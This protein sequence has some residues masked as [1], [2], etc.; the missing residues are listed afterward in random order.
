MVSITFHKKYLLYKIDM[1]RSI[2]TKDLVSLDVD[3][4]NK[5]II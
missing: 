4:S 2:M 3:N 5:N 1:S